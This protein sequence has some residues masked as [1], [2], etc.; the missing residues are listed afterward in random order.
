MIK[1]KLSNLPEEYVYSSACFYVLNKQYAFVK[2]TQWKDVG[3]CSTH[4]F[5][6]GDDARH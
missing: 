4:R 3:E 1:W 5:L 6:A 2:L